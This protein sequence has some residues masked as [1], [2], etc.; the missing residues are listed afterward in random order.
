MGSYLIE[1]F[2][3][4]T[5]AASS[6]DEV[7]S[8]YMCALRR[9]GFD[10]AIYTFV[11]DF[12]SIHQKAGHGVQCNFPDDWMEHYRIR[13]YQKIDPVIMQVLRSAAIFTWQHLTQT[14]YFDAGQLRILDEGNEAGLHDGVGIPL[15]GTNGGVAGVG[16][17]SS[18]GGIKPD[19][20]MLSKI[21][22]ITE[23]F[24]L[25]YCAVENLE[26]DIPQPKLT[27]KEVEVLKWWAAGKSSDEIALIMCSSRTTIKFHVTNIYLK[28]S[29][30]TKILA[31][32][33]AIR[34]GLVP[35]DTIGV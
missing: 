8:L 29:A 13:G 11:T 2:I 6:R 5:N 30:N 32:T 19:K 31:V 33:K 27:Q 35:L 9:L 20:N 21:K 14:D 10:R 24:H 1:E 28:L 4:H 18:L 23:Q 34:L 26:S 25:A 16:M 17:A 22:L 15:Y 3:E 7:F 12:P